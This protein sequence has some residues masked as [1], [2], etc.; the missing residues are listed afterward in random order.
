MMIMTEKPYDDQNRNFWEPG[1]GST[2]DL[3]SAVS[4]DSKLKG[5]LLT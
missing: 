1:P 4:S 2:V 3:P 5:V